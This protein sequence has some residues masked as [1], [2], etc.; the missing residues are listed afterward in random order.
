VAATSG[1]YGGCSSVVTLFFTKQILDQHRSACCSIFMKEKPAVGSP[2]LGAFPSGRIP[3]ATKDVNVHFSIHSSNTRK[4]YQQIPGPFWSYY[5]LSF[6]L[7]VILSH[8]TDC[9][10]IRMCV[11][12][13][14]HTHT[15]IYTHIHILVRPYLQNQ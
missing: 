3:K 9:V 6:Q 8:N 15:Y 14:I 11:C 4:L 7:S 2:F 1:E 5:V 10:C 12:T 13:Y